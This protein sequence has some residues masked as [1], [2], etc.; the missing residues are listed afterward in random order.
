MLKNLIT[1][2]AETKNLKVYGSKEEIGEAKD[3]YLFILI[4][5]G[6]I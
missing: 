5:F 2:F 4:P 3:Y 1:Q 6:L